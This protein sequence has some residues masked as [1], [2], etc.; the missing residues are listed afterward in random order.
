[1]A[2]FK[3]LLADITIL[4]SP[5]RNHF[6]YY[7]WNQ[8]S[9]QILI[10][11]LTH[12]HTHTD[13]CRFLFSGVVSLSPAVSL[14]NFL[15]SCETQSVNYSGVIFMSFCSPSECLDDYQQMLVRLSPI[16]ASVM[17]N[18]SA[19]EQNVR[20]GLKMQCSLVWL[21]SSVCNIYCV[22]D[23]FTGVLQLIKLGRGRAGGLKCDH[24]MST[25]K[26]D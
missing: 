14:C 18:N 16:T 19:Q 11:T 1:M 7:W 24:F 4:I 3:I 22:M 20:N 23:V 5:R 8:K 2:R 13:D 9:H 10:C 21:F 6:N 12:T 26:T 25:A 15:D 17:K